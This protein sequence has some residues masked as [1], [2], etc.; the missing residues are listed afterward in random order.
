M[1]EGCEAVGDGWVAIG[2]GAGGMGCRCGGGGGG[3]GGEV[4]GVHGDGRGWGW[5]AF[6]CVG[7]DCEA[8]GDGWVVMGGGAR[9]VG[10]RCGDGGGGTD[11]EIGG[12]QGDGSMRRRWKGRWASFDESGDWAEDGGWGG[13]GGDGSAGGSCFCDRLRFC[14]HRGEM[15]GCLGVSWHGAEDEVSPCGS[16]G[17]MG[18]PS[19]WSLSC[20]WEGGG[21]LLGL[22]SGV[23]YMELPGI[24]IVHAGVVEVLLGL[25]LLP[26]VWGSSSSRMEIVMFWLVTFVLAS[27]ACA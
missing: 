23:S 1:G 11:A 9:G 19:K 24:R 5:R 4:G 25:R 15:E 12:A 14:G 3:A 7:E 6:R 22:E 20:K 26:R 27:E 16:P 13:R 2:G 17:R 8:V 21:C 18:S 10:C